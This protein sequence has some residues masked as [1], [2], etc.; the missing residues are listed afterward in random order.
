MFSTCC[1]SL[2]GCQTCVEQQLLTAE[3]CLK[4]RAEELDSMVKPRKKFFRCLTFFPSRCLRNNSSISVS[5]RMGQH[6]TGKLHKQQRVH[7]KQTPQL[8]ISQTVFY[9]SFFPLRERG[10]CWSDNLSPLTTNKCIQVC[11]QYT[12]FKQDKV[13]TYGSVVKV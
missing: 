5:V 6:V 3:H 7:F 1:K 10:T 9:L 8:P 11:F 12:S 4:C 13:K 2:V